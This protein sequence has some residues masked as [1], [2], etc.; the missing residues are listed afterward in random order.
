[1]G[2]FT[3]N[4]R[5]AFN[6]RKNGIALD[7][8]KII[9]YPIDKFVTRTFGIHQRAYHLN[10]NSLYLYYSFNCLCLLSQTIKNLGV[11]L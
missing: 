3:F 1:M 8:I 4:L 2:Q 11:Y 9:S 7:V 10:R 6:I 5:R